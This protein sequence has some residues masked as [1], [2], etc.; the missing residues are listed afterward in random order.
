MEIDNGAGIT[1]HVG[2]DG[3]VQA[4]PV[5]LLHGITSSGGTWNWLVPQLADRYR[6]RF[7]CMSNK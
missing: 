3:P 4:P 6:C 5:V 1:L 7:S 2:E